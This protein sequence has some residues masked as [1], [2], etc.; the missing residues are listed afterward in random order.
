MSPSL[1]DASESE[2]CRIAWTVHELRKDTG[3]E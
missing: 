3:A 2:Q 1:R